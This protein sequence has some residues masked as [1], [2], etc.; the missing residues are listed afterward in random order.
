MQE[1]ALLGRG[2]W[3]FAARKQF[4]S[5]LGDADT[6]ARITGDGYKGGGEGNSTRRPGMDVN[7]S[8]TYRA[9]KDNRPGLGRRPQVNSFV[10]KRL[11]RPQN[12]L[13]EHT[14]RPNKNIFFFA[15]RTTSQKKA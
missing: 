4:S 1:R 6:L 2:E 15:Q 14:R 12:E 9:D 5:N 7:S 8:A 3:S 10:G 13:L 11:A